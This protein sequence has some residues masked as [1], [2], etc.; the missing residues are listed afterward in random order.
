MQ[1]L[2]SVHL[3]QEE[4][5]KLTL[6]VKKG[7]ERAQVITRARVLLLANAGKTDKAIARTLMLS[8]KTPFLIRK[9]RTTGGLEFALY[10]RPR[11]GQPRRFNGKQ[12]AEIVAIACTTAPKGYAHWTLDLLT[13]QVRGRGIMIGRTAVWKV[14]LRNNLKPW[15]K[16]NV[17]HTR[18]YAGV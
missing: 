16:K 18:D 10:D 15:R 11:P 4:R 7:I 6:M 12:E 8:T 5:V 9:R 2:H 3:S 17:V 1:K 14:L 13:E